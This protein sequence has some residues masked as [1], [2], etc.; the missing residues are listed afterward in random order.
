[1]FPAKYVQLKREYLSLLF[2]GPLHVVVEYCINGD[3]FNY[4]R[5]NRVDLSN[6]G[7]KECGTS[8][9]YVI[10]LRIAFDIANGMDYLTTRGVCLKIC[11]RAVL[12][13]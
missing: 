9:E 7:R 8:I 6:K 1:M 13:L 11:T 2:S 4:V 5:K 3:L 12:D 10:R